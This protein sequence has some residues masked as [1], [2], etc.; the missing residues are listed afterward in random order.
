MNDVFLDTAAVV[1]PGDSSGLLQIQGDLQIVNRVTYQWELGQLDGIAGTLDGWDLLHVNGSVHFGTSA[2]LL[3]I[4]VLATSA[5]T[6]LDQDLRRAQQSSARWQILASQ[7]LIDFSTEN[8][9][10]DVRS[11]APKGQFTLDSDASS[12]FLVYTIPEPVWTT[13][14][15]CC[16][17]SL[18]ITRVTRRGSNE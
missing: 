11:T 5:I 10:I 1:A 6:H 17:F 2:R 9:N 15:L 4:Q 7:R 14:I 13:W 18:L 3:T 16:G 12:L 8:V